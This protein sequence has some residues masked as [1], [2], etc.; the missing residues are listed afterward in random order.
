MFDWFSDHDAL[1]TWMFV[2]SVVMFVGTLI[3]LPILIVRMSPDYF[4]HRKPPPDSWRGSHPFV[5]WTVLIIKNVVG[6][7]LLIAGLVMLLTPGQG[8]LSILVGLSMMNVP[9]KRR[10]ELRLVQSKPVLHAINWIRAK[11]HRPPLQVPERH[12]P[13]DCP[14]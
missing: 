3:V 4:L 9:G 11:S 1:L 8:I 7:A 10:L 12:P 6:A 13:H 14:D 5:R 2:L